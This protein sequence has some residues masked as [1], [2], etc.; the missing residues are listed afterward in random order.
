MPHTVSKARAN[1][2]TASVQLHCAIMLS[3]E[4][5]TVQEYQNE[6]CTHKIIQKALKEKGKF[7]MEII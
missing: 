6:T 1:Q 5:R 2:C 7:C 4:Q 3:Y